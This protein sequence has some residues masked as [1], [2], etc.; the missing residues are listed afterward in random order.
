MSANHSTTGA[1]A[2]TYLRKSTD[3][4]EQSIGRQRGQ[5]A[6]YA[7]GRGYR[8]VQEYVDEGIAGDVFDRRPGF[9]KLLAAAQTKASSAHYRAA[10]WR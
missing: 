8:I 5:V 9:Q 1:R 10:P 4:Q 3:E 7:A 6:V 2:A